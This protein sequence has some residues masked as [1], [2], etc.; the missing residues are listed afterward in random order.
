MIHV[1]LVIIFVAK[2]AGSRSFK[3]FRVVETT[4]LPSFPFPD[5]QVFF[6]R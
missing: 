2:V 4:F 3:Q 1:F 5:C 6:F